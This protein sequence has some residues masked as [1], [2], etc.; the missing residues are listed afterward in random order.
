VLE[1]YPEIVIEPIWGIAARPLPSP[2]VFTSANDRTVAVPT[3]DSD[4]DL[5]FSGG[6]G[7]ANSKI[8]GDTDIRSGDPGG[9]TEAIVSHAIY[10]LGHDVVAVDVNFQYL[11]GYTP[12]AGGHKKASS[13]SVVILD[14]SDTTS[15]LA[16]VCDTGPLGN[17][18]WDHGDSYSPKIHCGAK[19]LS[20]HNAEAVLIALRFT[21][22]ERN[23]QIH[24]D[25]HN[26]LDLKIQWAATTSP[27]PSPPETPPP[28]GMSRPTAAV[29]VLRGPLL[30]A[31]H[32]DEQE[33][34]VKTWPT[35]N[36]T[37]V[38]LRT[39]TQ[40]NQ[41]LQ[42]RTVAHVPTA[43]GL[44]FV[45]SSEGG[46]NCQLPFNTSNF[47]GWITAEARTLPGWTTNSNAANEPPASPVNCS[48]VKGG[49]GSSS[50][51]HLVPYGA[52]NL[53]M[54]ALPWMSKNEVN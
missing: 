17:Y 40:W 19:G 33:S 11:A 54:A 50:V 15:T 25:P 28:G 44:E 2:V 22:N 39:T 41:A 34:I 42:L 21:N 46:P 10:G 45:R 16:T 23:L 37:D 3:A 32:L 12:P 5:T 36:N 29:A 9:V 53:R 14:A 43:D 48:S 51:I 18:S 1:L 6:A 49:C 30:F 27:S 13:V 38:D 52:T 26:G 20:V 8:T 47:F 7:A 35:F 4:V 24:L 31:L